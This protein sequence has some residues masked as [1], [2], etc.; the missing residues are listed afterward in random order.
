M[1]LFRLFKANYPT[2]K[3]IK[4][5]LEILGLE[6]E[7]EYQAT[8]LNEIS[9]YL[10]NNSQKESG[11]KV[12]DFEHDYKY[13]WVDFFKKGINLNIDNIS[14]WEFDAVL[15]GLFLEENS[16]ISKV[17]QYRTYKKPTKNYKT[18]ENEEHK[19]NM[20][21]KRQYALPIEENQIKVEN[22]LNSLFKFA[23]SKAKR[24]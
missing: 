1:K 18:A 23:E 20:E 10:F 24:G 4:K 3:E 13:Y 14:W 2:K 8:V 5:G 6:I 19:Y 9:L 21:K 15:E 12:F 17:I 16:I 11:T 7:E 22:G